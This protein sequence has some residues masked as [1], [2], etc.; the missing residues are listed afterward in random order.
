M[1]I[2]PIFDIFVIISEEKYK[3]GKLGKKKSAEERERE[4]KRKI[5]NK[6]R[7]S[8]DKKG[9]EDGGTVKC[10]EK[11]KAKFKALLAIRNKK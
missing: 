10:D 2:K 1:N 3:I 9:Y 11:R 6:L 7:D 4:R 8:S 5:S